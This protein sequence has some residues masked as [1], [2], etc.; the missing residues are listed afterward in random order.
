M[1]LVMC[2][3]TGARASVSETNCSH[4][5][6]PS[7]TPCSVSDRPGRS[8]VPSTQHNAQ[9][10]RPPAASSVSGRLADLGEAGGD[11]VDQGGGLHADRGV[12]VGEH[13]DLN[14]VGDQRNQYAA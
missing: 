10:P 14:V 2:S 8:G 9:R 7:K 12:R 1:A 13:A 4:R 5:V 3:I 11:E 6:V